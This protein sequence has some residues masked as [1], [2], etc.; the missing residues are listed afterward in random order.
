MLIVISASVISACVN[1]DVYFNLSEGSHSGMEFDKDTHHW[2]V[3][4]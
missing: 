1:K 4:Q 2:G 3:N